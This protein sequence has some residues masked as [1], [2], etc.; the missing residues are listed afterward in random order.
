MITAIRLTTT[1]KYKTILDSAQRK[2]SSKISRLKRTDQLEH[3][4]ELPGR[5]TLRKNVGTILLSVNL[6]HL[7]DLL[8]T[9]FSDP[10]FPQ[11][12]RST[13]LGLT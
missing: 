5:H 6:G 4:L 7:D 8:V 1:T 9:N 11:V 10:V 2:R 13:N 3:L 12:K